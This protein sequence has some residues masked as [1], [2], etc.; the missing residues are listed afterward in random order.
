MHLT[1]EEWRQ[2]LTPEQ[3]RVLRGKGTELPGSGALLHNDRTGAYM[4]AACGATLFSSDAKYESAVPGLMGWPSF[5]DPAGN[6]AVELRPDNSYG[7][8][9]TEVV[10]RNC[11][12]HLGHLFDDATSPTNKHYC[13][14]SCALD[15]RPKQ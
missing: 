13:I 1:D 15:F 9:R 14:N 4:C 3:Y 5:A 6:D 11:G 7:M 8:H 2:R 10:C 12:G